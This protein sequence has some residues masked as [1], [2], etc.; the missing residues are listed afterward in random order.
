MF[1]ASLCAG[2]QIETFMWEAAGGVRGGEEHRLPRK[3]TQN[4]R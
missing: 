2:M 3:D 4:R 1:A